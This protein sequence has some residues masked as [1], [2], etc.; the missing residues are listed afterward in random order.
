MKEAENRPK[1]NVNSPAM[2]EVYHGVKICRLARLPENRKVAR[3]IRWTKQENE[4]ERCSV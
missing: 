3:T 1:P 4:Q 2:D